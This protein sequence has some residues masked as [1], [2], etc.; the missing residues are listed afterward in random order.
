MRG[1]R[2]TGSRTIVTPARGDSTAP[3]ALC[4]LKPESFQP[5]SRVAAVSVEA[6]RET[7][8]YM[9]SWL[10]NEG[11]GAPVAWLAA[12]SVALTVWPW[13]TP[14]TLWKRLTSGASAAAAGA[15]ADRSATMTAAMTLMAAEG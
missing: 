11:G 10:T 6:M 7:P 12:R 4:G 1:T 5:L 14:R 3:G 8:E 15:A 13:P 9:A 2:K